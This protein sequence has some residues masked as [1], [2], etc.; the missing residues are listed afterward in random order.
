MLLAVLLSVR[1]ILFG[2]WEAQFTSSLLLSLPVTSALPLVYN[3]DM[4]RPLFSQS[5]QALWKR[6]AAFLSFVAVL[7]ALIAPASM[8]AEEVRTGKLGGV[9]LVNSASGTSGDLAPSGSHCDSCGSLAFALPPFA[10][11]PLHSHPGH[12]VASID[13]PFELTARISG[14]PPSRGPPAL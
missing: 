14:L 2:S 11:Q 8:L 4:C 1:D 12:H 9:C 3:A 7:S 6:I 10:A 13:L 5:A